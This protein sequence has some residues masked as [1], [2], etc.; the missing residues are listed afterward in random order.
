MTI[1]TEAGEVITDVSTGEATNAP[2]GLVF[3]FGTIS[4]TTTSPVGGSVT[5]TFD[6]SADLPDPLSIYKVDKNGNYNELP[7]N[8]WKKVD[9][10]TVEVT[11]TDGDA[12]TDMDG[13]ANGSIEDPIAVAG[14]QSSGGGGG[15]NDTFDFGGGGC[16]IGNTQSA[17]MD[18]IWL[19][20]LLAPGLG[21]LRRRAAATGTATKK[22][23]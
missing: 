14:Q 21:I 6:F 9:A 16:T 12:L 17:R 15:D 8:L 4:Y 7:T 19:F 11:V 22:G 1:S 23:A 3:P 13:V 18:P 20:L 5:M 10:N 2:G